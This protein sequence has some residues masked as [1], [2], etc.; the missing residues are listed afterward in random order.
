MCLCFVHLDGLDLIAFEALK[1][2]VALP[3]GSWHWIHEGKTAKCISYSMTSDGNIVLIKTLIVLSPTK[4]SFHFGRRQISL[5]N[6]RNTY[7]NFEELAGFLGTLERHSECGGIINAELVSLAPTRKCAFTKNGG[8]LRSSSCSYV[9]SL[10][11]K[12]G[13][14]GACYKILRNLKK[15]ASHH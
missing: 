10:N 11:S 1:S 7:S 2:N 12:H 3:S 6:A 14:C 15:K 5:P 9:A 13:I 4:V 8:V